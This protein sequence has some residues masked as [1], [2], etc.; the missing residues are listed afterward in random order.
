MTDDDDIVP[1]NQEG[2]GSDV[3]F[4][5]R[6]LCGARVSDELLISGDGTRRER[7][8]RHDGWTPERVR[9]F[10]DTLAA[11]GVVAD[12]ARAA[13][14]TV[15]T[16]Y[17]LRNRAEGGAFNIAWIAAQLR[18]RRRLA[19]TV[20]SRALHGCVELVVRDGEVVAE[21]HRFD[22]RLTMA[23]LNRLDKLAEA[24]DDESRAARFIAQEFDQFVDLVCAGG[25]SAAAFIAA[26]EVADM[27]LSR[28]DTARNLARLE[29]YRRQGDGLSEEAGFSNPARTADSNSD[30]GQSDQPDVANLEPPAT[31]GNGETE[32]AATPDEDTPRI[33]ATWLPPSDGQ[34]KPD[35]WR[36]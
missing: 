29:S 9:I 16:A 18:A 2:E 15:Q 4:A 30:E 36:P 7:A 11:C 32:P 23:T 10:L 17:R 25:D 22:N 19:D 12:A 31:P 34:E 13:G 24:G 6:R 33:V 20:L 27:K 21:R 1:A 14:M 8:Q 35:E 5:E 3:P 26:R 28:N